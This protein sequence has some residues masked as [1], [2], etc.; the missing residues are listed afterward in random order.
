MTERKK[1]PGKMTA[2]PKHIDNYYRQIVDSLTGQTEELKE[3]PSARLD[4]GGVGAVLELYE[5]T[6]GVAREACIKAFRRVILDNQQPDQIVAQA[7]DL[8]VSLDLTQLEPS[9]RRL[10]RRHGVGLLTKEAVEEY[11]NYRRIYRRVARG[12]IPKGS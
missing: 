6:S 12:D 7:V 4:W 1:W 8:V 9:I 5:G 2:N 11:F 3:I 10:Q